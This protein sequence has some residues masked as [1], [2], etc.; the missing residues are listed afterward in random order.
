MYSP[1]QIK[2]NNRQSMQ[3]SQ[4]AKKG[5]NLE[6][7]EEMMS[8]DYAKKFINYIPYSFGIVPRQG[9]ETQG[10]KEGLTSGATLFKHFTGTK[11]IYAHDT[12]VE[13]FDIATGEFT[14]IKDDFSA[15]T[16]WGGG[17]YGDNF[18]VTNG[19]DK[20]YRINTSM[21]ASIISNAPICDDIVFIGTRAVAI[22][23][24]TD[25]TAV[26]LSEDDDGTATPFS[27]WN[28]GTGSTD[29]A[30]VRY[31]NAG[32]ARSVVPLGPYYVVL[33]DNGYFSFNIR[34]LDSNGTIK[35]V[36]E[37]IDYI[38]DFGGGRGAISTPM[39]VFYVNEVGLWQLLQVGQTDVPYSR[40]QK[41]TSVLLNDS[42]FQNANFAN[43]ELVYDE[44]QKMIMVSYAD[45]STVNNRILA[46]KKSDEIEAVFE[47]EGWA[48]NRFT[49]YDDKL[50]GCS[51]VDGKIYECF[52]GW[53]DNGADV[54]VEYAQE[55]PLKSPYLRH[56]VNEFAS[57]GFLSRDSAIDV[58]IDTYTL[59]GAPIKSKCKKRWTAN[60]NDD[61]A[62]GWGSSGWNIDAWGGDADTSK[63]VE[64]MDGFNARINR[65]QRVTVR[66]TSNVNC[67][68]VIN[69]FG[70]NIED[71][72]P[73]R[74]RGMTT[75][76]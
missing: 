6:G 64:C 13:Y 28:T 59:D 21:V 65:A 40:Q 60:R 11:F 51:S 29:G 57:K 8:L 54:G 43:T 52:K 26:Q 34:Q 20:P 18:I 48:I 73:I 39:G 2:G 47:F 66:F 36:E 30:I 75:I 38:A 37:T 12:V 45:G 72:A 15:N 68:H 74:M 27:A 4:M 46:Y 25:E 44:T 76:T 58:H 1:L 69:W 49:K 56:R 23:L 71:G 33:S 53:T 19:V 16:R 9:L 70:C 50:Y 42:Y 41:L 32:K 5:L 17:R 7:L 10:E 67:P 14:V 31:R 61:K 22:S 62:K 35:K 24:S 55:L 3:F 63:M